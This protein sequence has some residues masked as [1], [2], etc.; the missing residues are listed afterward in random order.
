MR[1][2]VRPSPAAA[3][4]GMAGRLA[5]FVLERY[6]FAT[7]LVQEVIGVT[8]ASRV[9]DRDASQIESLRISFR[10]EL[11]RALEGIEAGELPEPTP[12]VAAED[13]LDA[14]RK[15]L[16]A[17]CDGFLVREAIAASL[18]PDERREILR[19][20]VLTRAVDNRLKQ[21]FASGEVRYGDAPFQGKGFRSLGQEAIYAA[22]RK[23]T[24]LKSSHIQKSRMPSSA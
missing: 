23:S 9:A 3:A 22:D 10:K 19:G 24:R 1:P 15:D 8:G 4:T 14:A 18:T 11:K 17:A 5:S 7:S 20:M 16:M 12:R 2:M 6:P 13:R 21:F